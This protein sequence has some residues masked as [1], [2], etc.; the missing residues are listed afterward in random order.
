MFDKAIGAIKR[1]QPGWLGG[2][3]TEQKE[4]VKTKVQSSVEKIIEK[5]DDIV[6]KD[7]ILETIKSICDRINIF[8]SGNKNGFIDLSKRLIDECTSG[9]KSLHDQLKNIKLENIYQVDQDIEYNDSYDQADRSV[10]T[11]NNDN[12]KTYN[13]DYSITYNNVDIPA[14]KDAM[15]TL[16]KQSEAEIK[17][18]ESQNDY[19]AKMISNIDSL[20]NKLT[21]L[22]PSKFKQQQNNMIIPIIGADSGPNVKVYDSSHLKQ[23]QLAY[24]RVL[25]I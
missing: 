13:N 8:F 22:D 11:I 14:L 23:A 3:K 2:N 10:K 12:H 1:V 24:A 5:Q 4:Q 18:L 7:N 21:W 25:N 20:G 17:L 19:L 16:Q 9:F 6:L 15:S